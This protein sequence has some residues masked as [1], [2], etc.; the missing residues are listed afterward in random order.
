[1]TLLKVESG[2]A[3]TTFGLEHLI[4]VLL[5]IVFVVTITIVTITI[6]IIIIAI[7][8]IVDM[9][10]W[11]QTWLLGPPAPR[12]KAALKAKK[13]MF[14]CPNFELRKRK[15]EGEEEEE[16]EEEEEG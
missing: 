4:V 1:M 12:P 2:A 11:W 16:E 15:E 13:N 9:I 6:T 3:R 8:I 7:L 10:Y 5:V 14:A